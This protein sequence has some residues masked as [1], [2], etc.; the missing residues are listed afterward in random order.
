MTDMS[1][2]L[3]NAAKALVEAVNVD[4]NGIPGMPWSGNG[5]LISTDTVKRSDQLRLAIHR[6]EKARDQ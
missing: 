6:Y 3:L 1:T 5:G 4:L 2:D